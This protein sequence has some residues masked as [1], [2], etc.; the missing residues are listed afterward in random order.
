MRMRTTRAVLATLVAGSL[1][2]VAACSGDAENSTAGH[3]T[4]VIASGG[5]IPALDPHSISGTIGLRVTD[6][7]YD[8]L[9]REDLE[10]QTK[11]APEILPSLAESW[12][13]SP[14]G[15]VYTFQIR[16][17]VSSHD[18][19]ALDADAVATNF[20]RLMD[21][22]SSVFAE[23]SSANM[24][25]VTR[26][27]ESA[28]ATDEFTF[29]ITLN[30]PF[31]ELPRLL[32]DRRM[33]IISPTALTESPGE[34]VGQHPSGTGPFMVESVE[35]GSDLRLQPYEG[36]WRGT[37]QL[38]GLV[39]VTMQDP[40]TMT[41]ALQTGEIDAILSA[42]AEQVQQLEGED[43]VVQYPDPANQ[44]F[45]RLNTAAAPTDNPTF[46][47]ALNYAIDRDGIIAAMDGMGQT[48]GGPIPTG[49]EAY[50][51]GSE[52]RYEFDQDEA[53][54][55]IQ[56]SGVEVPATVSIFAP[57]GGPGFSQ[58]SQIMSLVQQNLADVDIELEVE[59]VEFTSMVG[60]ES[61]GYTADVN[62]SFNGWTTGADSGYWFERMFGPDQVPPN[63]VNRG[64]YAN[65]ELT[66][67]FDSA[68]QNTDEEL[69]S[70]LYRD[71]AGIIAE[72]APWIFLYQDRLPRIFRS[73]IDGIYET[74]SVFVD[75]ATI[76]KG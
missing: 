60:L 14:D 62:G 33:A 75:Y 38:D 34:Q 49:N 72:D 37:P 36:H 66:S 51:E 56:E 32:T 50:E 52:A 47:Q 74:P 76:S 11:E 64:W 39:F 17:G 1:I 40:S 24:S 30:Q 53:R 15:L 28:E 5:E 29:V 23:V 69:R 16:E 3:E 54:R 7:I 48:L 8:T 25:F 45:I 18:G 41:T 2:G 22:Q 63:G 9:V 35:R 58:A 71:A 13:V 19:T 4:F 10:T 12:E 42:S 6:A 65:P 68:R 31:A 43:T 46:R 73:T 44:Y 67:L 26:W 21:E 59:Y 27:I 55:L 20:D 70:A 57:S 61:P